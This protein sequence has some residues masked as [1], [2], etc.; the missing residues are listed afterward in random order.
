[1]GSLSKTPAPPK[2]APKTAFVP[3]SK[4]MK[5]TTTFYAIQATPYTPICIT[6]AVKETAK[7][8]TATIKCAGRSVQAKH[9]ASGCGYNKERHAISTATHK[10]VE[11]FN[12]KQISFYDDQHNVVKI[13]LE[14]G[15][16]Q[17]AELTKRGFHITEI[18]V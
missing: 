11:G 18:T 16:N 13:L 4:E 1:M 6:L 7:T 2:T 12:E 3:A 5:M 14:E 15:K 17:L 9:T 10:L 8:V